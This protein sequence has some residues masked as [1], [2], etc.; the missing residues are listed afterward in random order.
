MTTGNPKV[1]R[2][3]LENAPGKALLLVFKKKWM[4][5][6]L[7]LREGLSVNNENY[8]FFFKVVCQHDGNQ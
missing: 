3:M 4:W 8:E 7:S 2:L 1:S 6:V 5:P